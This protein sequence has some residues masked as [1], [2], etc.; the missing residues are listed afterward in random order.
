[1]NGFE[2]GYSM[3]IQKI[4]KGFGFLTN[5]SLSSPPYIYNKLKINLQRE[6]KKLKSENNG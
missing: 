4:K 2:N 6:K 1:M 5:P 3:E